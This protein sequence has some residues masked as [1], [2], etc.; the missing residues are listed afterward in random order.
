MGKTKPRG[1]YQSVSLPVNFIQKIK[2]Q[3]MKDDRYK[4]IAD[5]VKQAVREKMDYD[6]TERIRNDFGKPGKDSREISK[7]T[8]DIVEIKQMIN[9]LQK[10][11]KNKVNSNGHGLA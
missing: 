3:V 7:L 1:I 2:K 10:N 5:Y 8:R 11:S 9:D 6:T 4:S